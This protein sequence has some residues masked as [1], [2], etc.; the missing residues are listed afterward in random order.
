MARGSWGSPAHEAVRNVARITASTSGRAGQV[1]ACPVSVFSRVVDSSCDIDSISW[2]GLTTLGQCLLQTITLGGTHGAFLNHAIDG[3][4]W[5]RVLNTVCSVAAED[6]IVTLHKTWIGVA[7]VGSWSAGTATGFLH[8]HCED[9][10]RVE[11]GSGSD[12]GGGL[13]DGVE[14]LGRVVG[15]TELGAGGLENGEVGVPPRSQGLV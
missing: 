2:V 14:L 15:L 9:D 3:G 5:A 4:W 6:T 1:L 13:L 11:A 12:G 10:T 8:D 7:I